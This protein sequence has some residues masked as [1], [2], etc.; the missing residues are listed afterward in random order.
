MSTDDT[1][2]AVFLGSKVSP[3]WAAW[4][5]LPEAERRAR[6]QRGIAAWKAWVEQHKAAIVAMVFFGGLKRTPGM[7][8]LAAGDGLFT[9]LYVAYLAGL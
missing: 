7:T 9:I 4:N 3:K 6:E 2:L 8:V 1:F 5:A